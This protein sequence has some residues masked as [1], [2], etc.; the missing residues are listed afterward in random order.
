[1]FGGIGFCG[2]MFCCLMFF[3]D[4]EFVFIK[5]VK[6]QNL[7]LN[8]MKILGFCGCLMCCLKYEN[9]EYEMVKEQFLDIGEMIMIVNGFVKVVGFNILEWVFQVELINCEKVIEYIWEEFL[10]EGVVF[11]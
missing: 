4:F 11:V 8:F 6:D 9:D 2:R 1:M 5:M 7:F 10:E 3:G